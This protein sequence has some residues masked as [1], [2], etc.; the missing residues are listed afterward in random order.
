M[1]VTVSNLSVWPVNEQF[2]S[3]ISGDFPAAFDGISLGI[4]STANPV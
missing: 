3:L 1:A 4:K 2:H